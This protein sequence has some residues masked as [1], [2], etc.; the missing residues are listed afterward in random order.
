MSKTIGPRLL[1]D[2]ISF[3][4]D[5]G[6]RLGIIGANG[7]GKTTL[8]RILAGLDRPDS[9]K[10][11]LTK[12]IRTGYLEQS[13]AFGDDE[14]VAGVLYSS[15]KEV[16]P[17]PAAQYNRVHAM[18]SRGE[19]GGQDDPIRTLS[20]GW[21]KR[22]A[23]CRALILRPDILLLDEPTNHL[24][25]EGILWLEQLLGG[26]FPESPAAFVLV[27]HDRLFLENLTNRLFEL[28]PAF[29]AGYFSVAGNYS[30]FLQR[31]EEFL[32]QQEKLEASLANKARRESEW[33]QRGPKARTT[34][35]K[36]RVDEA[37]RLH[38]E[39][40]RIKQ[41]NR[42][43]QT[44]QMDF[45]AT[46]RKTRKLL[47]A[48]RLAKSFAGKKLFAD[49]DLVLAPGK[50]LGLLGPNGCGKS[51]LMKILAGAG[52]QGGLQPDRGEIKIAEGVQI[53]TFTQNREKLDLS[54][55]LRQALSPEGD[56]VMYRDRPLHLV[57]WA[58]KF[59]FRADQ[60]DTP[61]GNLSGGEQ[62]KIILADLMRQPADILLL[63]EP[64]NDLDIPAL[65]VLEESLL[66]FPG[67]V[68]LVT[69]DRFLMSRVCEA[70]LGFCGD[71]R[72]EYF[73]DYEQWY[74]A[75]GKDGKK[76]NESVKNE[77]E[78]KKPKKK[79]GR[80]SYLEQ[81]EY[82]GMEE[83]ILQAEKEEEELLRIM[84]DPVTAAH[85]EKLAECW[86]KLEKIRRIIRELY[87]RWDELEEKKEEEV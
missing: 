69:H 42:A 64:T 77:K 31:K 20:G 4:L 44:V 29:P 28:S 2:S 11:T 18:L 66:E 71:G 49:L 53:V 56:T 37:H 85:P 8:L 76:G 19:F 72:V 3:T 58:R 87:M 67:A 14:T 51:T 25:L 6:D 21:R 9:G 32:E 41:R 78:K 5:R 60:L 10:V 55:T 57:T 70:V 36:Y 52:G 81:R 79:K 26:S 75:L 23:I 40:A 46:D 61:V 80:L 22:L 39:L 34:K 45:T 7:T 84:A 54:A 74:A 68:V 86:E 13:E 63:D 62:A 59:L 15:L 82:D 50:R 35:A 16:E 65:Q 38:E 33:L 83:S 43:R 27:S 48:K 73:S 30:E 17:D 47:E 1:F 12:N 24:D